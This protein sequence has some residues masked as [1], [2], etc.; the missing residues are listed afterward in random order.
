VLLPTG[1]YVIKK[2]NANYLI[3]GLD[4]GKLPIFGS[5]PFLCGNF[6]IS[7]L[8]EFFFQPPQ[9]IVVEYVHVFNSNKGLKRSCFGISS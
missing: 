7:I 9:C 4:F 6:R 2:E 8:S 3:S 1:Y 5:S